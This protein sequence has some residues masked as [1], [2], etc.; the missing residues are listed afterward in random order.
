VRHRKTFKPRL[1]PLGHLPSN[2]SCEGTRR[3][4]AASR[5]STLSLGHANG[6]DLKDRFSIR[7][8]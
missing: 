8:L 5:P 1:L 6:L 2:P 3:D 7:R 4:E